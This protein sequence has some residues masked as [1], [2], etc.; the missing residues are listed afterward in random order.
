MI[1]TAAVSVVNRLFACRETRNPRQ[2]VVMHRSPGLMFLTSIALAVSC[3]HSVTSWPPT[4]ASIECYSLL[5]RPLR[6]TPPAARLP[7]LERGLADARSLLAAAP[8]DP[9]GIIWLGRRLGYLWRMREAIDTFT[10]GAADFPSDPRFLRH[11]GHRYISVR[12]FQLAIADL[13]RAIPL[14]Q[15][16]PDCIEPDGQPNSANTPLTT[17]RFN[18]WYHLGVAHYMLAKFDEAFA[19]FQQAGRYANGHD[20]NVIAVMD[21]SYMSLR[22]SGR[23]AE[24]ERIVESAPLNPRIIENRA[25]AARL[26]LYAG[27]KSA[28]QLLVQSSVG[29]TDGVTIR[30]GV[31]NWLFCNGRRDEAVALYESITACDNWPAFALIA[32]EADLARLRDRR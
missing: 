22:R 23:D 20:D 29:D 24:A 28:D 21:W 17:T 13:K 30:Y 2:T 16:I 5:G 7:E 9:D 25:Y 12:Q 32:A 6:A 31:A 15:K 1:E 18:V 8:T 4:D 11:R 19:A 3:S 26:A 27:R 14:M 10:R